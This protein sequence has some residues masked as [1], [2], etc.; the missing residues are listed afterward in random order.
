MALVASR[1]SFY[2]R[3]LGKRRGLAA[4]IAK[5][6]GIK[7]PSVSFFL[8]GKTSSQRIHD[9]ILAELKRLGVDIPNFEEKPDKRRSK[10]KPPQSAVP[11]KRNL[12]LE[13][14]AD[15]LVA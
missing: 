14:F 2:R 12:L 1:L 7:N 9:A 15:E 4:K 8:R 6:L 11:K 13:D 3:E 10:K 5:K